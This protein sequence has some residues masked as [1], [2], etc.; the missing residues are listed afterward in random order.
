[1]RA[2]DDLVCAEGAQGVLDRP[3]GE[4]P[5]TTPATDPAIAK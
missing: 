3:Y 4:H 1:M 5:A 2:D